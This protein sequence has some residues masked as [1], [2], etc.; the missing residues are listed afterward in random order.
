MAVYEL[1]LTR[2]ALTTDSTTGQWSKHDRS[3]LC[4]VVEDV[5]R[6]DDLKTKKVPGK[7]AI[8]C[9]RYRL[10][11]TFS[12]KFGRKMWLVDGVPFFSGIRVHTGNDAGASEGCLIVGRKL[13]FKRV[14]ESVLALKDVE[15]YLASLGDPDKNEIWLTI[16]LAPGLK[17]LV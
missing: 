11:Y 5:Y 3:H 16:K 8:P 13:G 17:A 6:G 14:D 7:T 2:S 12:P 9:G 10:R 15:A 4:H 1:T